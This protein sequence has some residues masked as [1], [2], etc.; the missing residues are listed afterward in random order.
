MFVHQTA[1]QNPSNA[2]GSTASLATTR[3]LLLKWWHSPEI[4]REICLTKLPLCWCARRQ[5]TGK[6]QGELILY[7]LWIQIWFRSMWNLLAEACE[8]SQES[9]FYFFY[10]IGLLRLFIFF[11]L[12]LGTLSF[13]SLCILFLL[14]LG[15]LSLRSLLISIQLCR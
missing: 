9:F 13:R 3:R 12:S 2:R 10:L 4:W 7:H 6:T 1:V 14:S 11:L 15:K 8:H 5:C